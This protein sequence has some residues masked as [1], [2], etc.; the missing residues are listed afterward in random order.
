MKR[1]ECG[2]PECDR[3]EQGR[4]DA[5]AS[6]PHLKSSCDDDASPAP[7]VASP[8]FVPAPVVALVES[9]V[10]EEGSIEAVDGWC[11]RDS[12]GPPTPPPRD[13]SS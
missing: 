13:R 6:L 1:G 4:D 10:G 8:P 12:D 2:C 3:E 5:T 7:S 9:P 11:P